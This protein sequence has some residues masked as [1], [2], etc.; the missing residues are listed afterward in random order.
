[1][2]DHVPSRVS[3]SLCPIYP[4]RTLFI[5]LSPAVGWR[6]VQ[7]LWR[8]ASVQMLTGPSHQLYFFWVEAPEVLNVHASG[9]LTQLSCFSLIHLTNLQQKVFTLSFSLDAKE[10][11]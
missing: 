6:L 5:S 9:A 3:L 11:S 10:I 2:Q 4:V 1:M 7:L 8:S